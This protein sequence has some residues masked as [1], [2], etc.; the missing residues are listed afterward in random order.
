MAIADMFYIDA[1]GLHAPDYADVLA[2][3]K[4]EYK[5]IY[6]NDV[7]LEADSQDGQ[8]LAVQAM[9][10]YDTI[11]AAAAIYNSFSPMTALDDALDR[12]VK[13]NGIRRR[14]ATYSTVDL[15]ITGEAGTVIQDCLAEDTL[16]Q[17]WAVPTT[18]IPPA[19]T[20]TVTATS[21]TIGAVACVANS[22]TKIATP[23]LGWL[24]VNNPLA[25]KPGV[26]IE[27]DYELRQ[28]QAIST[29][30]P[31]L[32]I[33]DGIA[34]AVA[35]L[36]GVTRSKGYEND[37]N[38]TDSDGIPAHSIA[39]VVE[40]GVNYDIA[41]AIGRKKTPGVGTYG[42]TSA[43]YTDARS[44][45]N[46]INFLR[47]T[48]ATIGI[49]VT[50]KAFAGYTTG[51]GDLIKAELVKAITGLG[52]GDD[53]LITKLYVP[54][55]LPANAAGSTFNLTGLRTKKNAGDFGT[56]DIPIAFDEVAVCSA[57]N[58]TVIVV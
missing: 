11:Q 16:G 27:T 35:S 4:S 1:S 53:V 10:I 13:I 9:A 40:G 32:T 20:I 7:Y 14:P 5:A 19:C 3:L 36:S 41:N 33:L 15:V 31:S 23:T 38:A 8:W 37:S 57:A 47:P 25:A 22:V 42:T 55:N 29:A 21:V 52:I 56:A 58:I 28:R 51:F 34:G 50:I 45:E 46:V 39:M 30:I 17:K 12:N 18:T 2:Y 44:L 24:T 26:P 6:G 54:A 43:I 49:E 48:Q